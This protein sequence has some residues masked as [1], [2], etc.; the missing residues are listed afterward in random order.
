MDLPGHFCTVQIGHNQIEEDKIGL[1]FSRH[2]QGPDS[3]ILNPDPIRPG[4]F[5]VS[6]QDSR[7]ADFF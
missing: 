3:N 7:K 2:I 5:K 6:L 1:K 4:L